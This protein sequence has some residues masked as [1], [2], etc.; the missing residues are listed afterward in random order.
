MDG[1]RSWAK[2]RFLPAFEWHR[3][4][5]ENVKKI[6]RL[7]KKRKIPFVSIWAL[8]DDNIVNRS[9]EEVQYLFD[10]L[11]KGMR[12]IAVE[13]KEEGNRIIVVGDRTLLPKKCLESIEYAEEY[14]KDGKDITTLVAIA[15]GWQE[16]IIRGIKKLIEQGIDENGRKFYKIYYEEENWLFF[17]YSLNPYISNQ[18]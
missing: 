17:E 12:D 14:T 18:K 4:G 2:E 16:E 15:Y 3:R 10:L 8:S 13:A 11:T 6:L 1:N 5:Y 7:V 9:E